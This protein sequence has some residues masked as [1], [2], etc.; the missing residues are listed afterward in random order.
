MKSRS[1]YVV[2]ALDCPLIWGSKLQTETALSTMEAE[3]VSLLMC[4]KELIPLVRLVKGV[5]GVV[6]IDAEEVSWM[7]I[8]VHK[9][10]AGALMLAKMEAPWMTP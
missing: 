8:K 6:G 5:A 3:Y 7:H 4:M 2:T 9:G 10:N 1:G